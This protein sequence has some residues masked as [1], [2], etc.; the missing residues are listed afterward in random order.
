MKVTPKTKLLLRSL[1]TEKVFL[2]KERI[3]QTG[4]LERQELLLKKYAL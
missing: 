1:E 3:L 2:P 4:D